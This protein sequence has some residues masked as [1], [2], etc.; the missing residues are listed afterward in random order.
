MKS[1]ITLLSILSLV[2]TTTFAADGKIYPGSMG[3]RWN[4]ADP[5]P[6]LNF[7]SLE[8]PSSQW[9]RV[10]LPVVKDSIGNSIRSGLVKVV[11][12]HYSLDVRCNLVSIFRGGSAF[13]G[14]WSGN[15][16]STGSSNNTQTLSYPGVGANSSCHYYYSCHI[17]PVYAGNRSSIVSYR[18]DERS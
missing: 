10:D 12:R 4:G 6:A 2:A 18:V 1:F 8:N 13:A 15:R 7:S 9:L 5:L 14:W 17:P 11:D 16:F 3:V